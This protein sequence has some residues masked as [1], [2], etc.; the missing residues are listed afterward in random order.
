VGKVGADG[1]I[2]GIGLAEGAWI[3]GAS[4]ETGISIGF[5]PALV[6]SV[7]G[8]WPATVARPPSVT[9]SIPATIFQRDKYMVFTLLQGGNRGK[10]VSIRACG[11]AAY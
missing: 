9:L 2:F 11:V 10:T 8:H 5:L 1:G 3:E 6:V 4:A 7:L